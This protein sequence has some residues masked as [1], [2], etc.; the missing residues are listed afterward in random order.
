MGPSNSSYLSNIAIFHLHDYGRKSRLFRKLYLF[1]NLNL[2]QNM[3]KVQNAHKATC[4]WQG[5]YS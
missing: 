2:L 1:V 3:I 5:G 4:V